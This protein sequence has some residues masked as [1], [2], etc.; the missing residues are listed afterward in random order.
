VDTHLAG[1]THVFLSHMHEDHF[2]VAT[3]SRLDPSVT[4]LIP[5]QYPNAIMATRLRH[6][7]FERVVRLPMG[8]PVE[9][10]PDFGVEALLPMNVCGLETELYDE[11]GASITYQIDAGA[12][13][14]LGERRVVALADNHPCHPQRIPESMARMRGCDLLAFSYN[15]VASDY[16]LCYEDLDEAQ[17]A[18]I[19]R[20]R[21]DKRAALIERFIEMVGPKALLLYSSEFAIAGPQARRFAAWLQ[22]GWWVD[23]RG[24][25]RR[26]AE[27]SGHPAL[28]LYEGDVA[29]LG[30][31][32]WS[33]E[34]HAAPRPAL[35]QV[36]ASL[37]SE[38]PNTHARFPDT[39]AE[40]LEELVERAVANVLS[41]MERRRIACDWTLLLHAEH[42]PLSRPALDFAQGMRRAVPVPGA[43]LLSCR[44]QANY[45]A[46]LRGDCH[47]NSARISFNLR[48][49]RD[50]S[51]YDHDLFDLLNFLHVPRARAT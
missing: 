50:P 13:F 9:I 14:R 31:S 7:G 8:R 10:A 30:A 29:R 1:A 20:A 44:L 46:A 4:F 47:W 26:Y 33:V 17:V 34:E 22:N 2:D 16:P 48:W 51:V 12:L 23:K 18:A 11:G 5:D 15:G 45:L 3:L 39:T 19:T 38:T 32:G 35:A 28:A 24:A 36:A 49:R 41:V 42:T 27:R 6:L 21:E 43:R 37:Y 25:A 40:E